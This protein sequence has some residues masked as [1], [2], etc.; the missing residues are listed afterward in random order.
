MGIVRIIDTGLGV[1][2]IIDYFNSACFEHFDQLELVFG[3]GV[4]VADS[5]FH[6]MIIRF[7]GQA[8]E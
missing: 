6:I 4:V 8:G 5:Y 7:A 2:A 1:C 3:A